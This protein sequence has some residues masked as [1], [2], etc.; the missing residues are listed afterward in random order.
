MGELRYRRYPYINGAADAYCAAIN[1][2]AVE[3]LVKTDNRE[4]Y[5]KRAKQVSEL[6]NIELEMLDVSLSLNMHTSTLGAMITQ[7]DYDTQREIL[8]DFLDNPENRM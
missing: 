2:L 1:I 6:T 3:Y 4:E 5:S 7:G 8:M